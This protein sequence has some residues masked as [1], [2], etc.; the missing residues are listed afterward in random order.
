MPSSYERKNAESIKAL[1][2]R[3]EKLENPP[4]PE[5][6]DWGEFFSG[7]NA[8][9]EALRENEAKA[10]EIRRETDAKVA[11]IRRETAEAARKSAS[12]VTDS[13]FWWLCWA[14]GVGTGVALSMLLYLLMRLT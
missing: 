13:N 8:V 10:A 1:E 3:V 2:E 6:D 14:W 9:T 4:C 11:E 5:G 12:D 7:R